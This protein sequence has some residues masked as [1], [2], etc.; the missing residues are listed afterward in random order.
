MALCRNGEPTRCWAM[1]SGCTC[2]Q[3][4]MIFDILMI[5]VVSVTFVTPLSM[6][7]SMNASTPAFLQERLYLEGSSGYMKRLKPLLKATTPAS[8]TFL[9]LRPLVLSGNEV[10]AALDALFSPRLLIVSF[11][12]EELCLCIVVT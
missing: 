11:L 10:M 12:T 3:L 1:V 4:Y 2:I 5:V 8:T 7:S 6:I 9:R